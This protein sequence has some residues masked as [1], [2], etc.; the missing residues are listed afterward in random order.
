MSARKRLI[1]TLV[2]GVIATSLG[3]LWSLQG[4][5]LLRV[6]PLLCASNCKPVTGGSAPWLGI[7]VVVLALGIAIIGVALKGRGRKTTFGRHRPA[8]HS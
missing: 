2:V 7:G 3:A 1:L 5:G 8:R 6:R 4:A